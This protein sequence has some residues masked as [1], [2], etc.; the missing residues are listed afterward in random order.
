MGPAAFYLDTESENQAMD[1]WTEEKELLLAPAEHASELNSWQTQPK[2]RATHSRFLVGVLFAAALVLTGCGPDLTRPPA[3]P[4]GFV[5]PMVLELIGP[6]IARIENQPGDAEEH[7][8][9]ALMYEANEMW[10]AATRSFAQAVE[11]DPGNPIWAVHLYRC[12]KSLG[13]TTGE[14]QRL[15]SLVDR[16]STRAPF[17][18]HL[19]RERLE[20]GDIDGARKAFEDC[21]QLASGNPAV[22]VALSELET[23][24]G[25]SQQA[26]QLAQQALVKAPGHPAVLNARGQALRALGRSDE[27]QT[28][29]Q[30]GL[31]AS[32]IP[33]PDEGLRRLSGYYAAPQM[34][35]NHSADL[36]GAGFASRAEQ[37][38]HRVLL[39]RPGDRDALNNLALALKSLSRPEEALT[40]LQEALKSDADYFPTLINITDLLLAM[41]RPRD[42]L[43]HAHK[44]VRI[45]AENAI[46]HRLLGMTQIRLQDFPAALASFEQSLLLQP[47]NFDCHGAASEAALASGNLEAATRHLTEAS[48]LRPEFLPAQV[49]LVHLLI[50]QGNLED[51]DRRLQDLFRRLGEHPEVVK[52]YEALR[53]ARSGGGGNR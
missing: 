44:A 29:L 50:K 18:Y 5:E 4:V 46:A 9:L 52:A 11:L 35:I 7:G 16:F 2:K 39:A 24:L 23:L 21:Q 49:N 25:N 33:F 41:Q 8:T 45:D 27:A 32:R 14:W 3:R 10:E 1:V 31:N 51:A 20:N 26:L 17:L 42:A 53:R 12:R 43:I 40:R 30:A 36:I 19:G 38:L 22:L 37:L 13:E 48:K 15:E 47:G 34:L 6:Q 28:D